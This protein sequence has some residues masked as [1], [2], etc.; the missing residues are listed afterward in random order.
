MA[1]SSTI[2]IIANPVA[3][4]DIRRLTA[5]ASMSTVQHKQGIVARAILGADAVGIKR[6]LLMP[7]AMGIASGVIDDIGHR[8]KA[9]LIEL[10]MDL[11]FL[12][13]DSADAASAM[14]DQ[15]AGALIVLG[16]D[17]TN[18]MVVKG[19]NDAPTIPISTGTNNAFSKPY[20]ATMAGAAAA[21][22]AMGIC[23]LEESAARAKVVHVEIDGEAPDLALVDA[24]L[25]DEHLLGWRD[26]WKPSTL[27]TVVLS[28]A[29]A[30]AIGV[31]SIGGL[32]DP[33]L[34]EADHGL[35]LEL[36]PESTA[37]TTSLRVPLAPGRFETLHL[38]S[39]ERLNLGEDIEVTGEGLLSFDGERERRLSEGQTARFSVKRDGP[40]LINIDTVMDLAARRRVFLG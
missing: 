2:G 19:W 16:G 36:A 39:C 9:E 3:G 30:T 28:Q 34:A 25:T 26:L 14:C 6:I 7:S 22:L 38:A 5:K 31:S 4:K 37:S 33:C 20:E 11:Q 21:I 32:V 29:L 27:K 1:A 17:G 8:V 13:Q 10:D 18:R 15:G 24:L 35:V 12:P 23:N 40:Y